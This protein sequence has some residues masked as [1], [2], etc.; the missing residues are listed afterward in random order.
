MTTKPPVKHYSDL[1]FEHKVWLNEMQFYK[2]EIRTFH[3]RLEEIVGRYTDKTVL[4]QLEQFQ[5]R[6]IREK[7]VIDELHH[8][9]KQHENY[10]ELEIAKAPVASE[11]RLFNDHGV[12][13]DKMSSFS[14]LHMELKQEFFGFLSK[15]M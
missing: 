15:W 7:E 12:L 9:I 14:K 5:N 8:D 6:F 1:H 2:D 10:L 4:A 13:R 11:H 3:S